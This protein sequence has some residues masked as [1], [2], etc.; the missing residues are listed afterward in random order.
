MVSP[1][2]R[3]AARPCRRSGSSMTRR[4]R[5]GVAR[6]ARRRRS[7]RAGGRS[8]S[9]FTSSTGIALSMSCRSACTAV[10][11]ATI[12]GDPVTRG[13]RE[14]EPRV[15]LPVRGRVARRRRPRRARATRQSRCAAVQVERRRRDVAAPGLDDPA[16]DQRV[17]QLLA[18]RHQRAGA[19]RGR[20]P[21]L[22]ADHGA[23][24]AAAG[25][26]DQ[27]RPRAA[28]RSP[29]A[30]WRGRPPAA[31]RARAPAAACCRAGR[32]PAGSRWPAARRSPRTRGARAPARSTDSLSSMLARGRASR[33]S[34]VTSGQLRQW[35]DFIP[36]LP[37]TLDAP[38]APTLRLSR[39]RAAPS[40]PWHAEHTSTDEAALPTTSNSSPSSATPRS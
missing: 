6:R 5:S 24:A 11:A 3:A 20:L 2:G 31:R 32:R 8:A 29:R 1:A 37:A 22:V 16:E 34:L 23:A 12:S 7:R 4:A 17:E 14:V 30:G 33:A 25:R 13:D 39:P 28:R 9:M 27:R 38:R 35:S 36:I 19:A 10:T 18:A 15:G 21:G 26:L 40:P